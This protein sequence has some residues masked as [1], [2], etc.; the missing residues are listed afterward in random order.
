MQIFACLIMSIV[1]F[2][3]FAVPT[4]SA[5]APA[6]LSAD[7]GLK[8][9]LTNDGR[10][11]V[12]HIYKY[13]SDL[14]DYKIESELYMCKPV[15]QES[16]AA[17]YFFKRPNLVRL[18]IRSRGLKD[19]TIVV[20]QPDGRIRVAGGHKLRFLKM[21]VDEDS[22]ILQTPNGYNVIKSDLAS[23]FA[24]IS[25][26]LADGS[27]AQATASPIS[28]NRFKQSVTV[29]QLVKPNSGADQITDRIFIDPQTDT[30]LEWDIFRNGDRYSITVFD[31][32][33]ANIGLQDDQF[34]L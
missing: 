25:A 30:P 18:Q 8:D 34:K 33:N 29:L 16:G 19:G 28:L 3:L 11:L 5:T 1:S 14:K 9:R 24:A 6:D 15:M 31:N 7:E 23:L 27:K 13:L 21:N 2:L 20:R 17:V 22:R 10:K 32:F 26:A 4:V 12:D